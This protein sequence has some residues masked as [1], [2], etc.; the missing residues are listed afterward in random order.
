MSRSRWLPVIRERSLPPWS[1][2]DHRKMEAPRGGKGDSLIGS[3]HSTPL[4][5]EEENRILL[6]LSLVSVSVAVR[7]SLSLS[8]L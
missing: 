3:I 8:L 7:L 2:A 5:I 1:P 6:S 4:T